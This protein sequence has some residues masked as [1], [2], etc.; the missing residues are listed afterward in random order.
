MMPHSSPL[1]CAALVLAAALLLPSLLHA[2][3]SA[4]SAPGGSAGQCRAATE[5]ALQQARDSSEVTL[6]ARATQLALGCE[7][8]PLAL[9]A[10]RRWQA[11]QPFSGE[12][13]LARAI[14]ALKLYRLEEGR[15]A[16]LAWRDSAAGGNQ[17]PGRFVGLLEAEVGSTA[18]YRSFGPAL[19]D[20]NSNADVLLALAALAQG[21]D[22]QRNAMLHARRA[23]ALQDNLVEAQLVVIRAQAR[24][25][26]GEVALAAARE[27]QPR[28]EGEDS[29]I[30][31]DLLLLAGREE[32]AR[33]ELLRLRNDERQA[34]IADRRLGALALSQG[35]EA[36]A[37]R[38]FT[39]LLGQ[40]S[41]TMT[42]LLYLGQLAE[43]RGDLARAA[44]SYE[45]LA[46]G[47]ANLAARAALGRVWVRQGRRD[48]ALA[49]LEDFERRN[50]QAAVET[51]VARAQLLLRLD[52]GPAALAAIDAGLQRHPG[53]PDLEY[54]RATLLERIGRPRDAERA[55]EQLLKAR[56]EDPGIL[57][58]LGFTLADHGRQL[59]R[60]E[61]LIRA[62]LA[63]SPDSPAILDSLGWALFRRGRVAQALPVLERAWTLSRDAEI[64]AHF[65]EVLWKRGE[66]GRARY[67]WQQAANADP[68]NVLL[69]ATRQRLTG[70]AP[71]AR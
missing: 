61:R 50:P 45:L 42:A 69:I 13:A 27:M 14:A 39:A 40:R 54:E 57:N 3:Q 32:A 6:S 47:G 2:G 1:R 23:L 51:V 12:A 20:D 55:F 7:Q 28:L 25:G 49:L 37:E 67:V 68:A 48:A 9:E 53:H 30:V 24:L 17:D 62:A 16:L 63:V 56:P 5:Q 26:E 44:R 29:F 31:A 38:R 11:L 59:D 58:A 64:G 71:E 60:A 18:L 43:R 15:Q 35:D 52:D 70:E 4:P 66:E 8:V 41:T 36:E 34:M 65:G 33:E 46:E 19:V 21:S 22:D 10:A